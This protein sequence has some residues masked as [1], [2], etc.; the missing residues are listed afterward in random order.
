MLLGADV[1]AE[2]ILGAAP[3]VLGVRLHLHSTSNR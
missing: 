3:S 2:A 1:S